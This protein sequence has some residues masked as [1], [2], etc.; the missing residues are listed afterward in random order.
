MKRKTK[1]LS[2]LYLN[3]IIFIAL[4]VIFSCEKEVITEDP[5]C[6]ACTFYKSDPFPVYMCGYDSLQIAEFERVTMNY[7]KETE[8]W[9][10]IKCV[11]L[12]SE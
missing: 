6:W 9:R 11:K 4:L 5:D 3:N 2:I 1:L 8:I 12:K 7:D 10:N